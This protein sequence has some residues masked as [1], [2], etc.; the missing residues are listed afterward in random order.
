MTSSKPI[1]QRPHFQIASNLGLRLWQIYS[2]GLQFNPYQRTIP[3]RAWQSGLRNET[4]NRVQWGWGI[5]KLNR[6]LE[7]RVLCRKRAP[8]IC[9]NS[10]WAQIKMY[11][12]TEWNS[13][14][15][16]DQPESCESTISQSSRRAQ[17]AV[18]LDQPECNILFHHERNSIETLE[19]PQ[20]KA[21]Y[22]LARN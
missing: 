11:A 10:F 5:W 9:V 14:L 12:P 8:E 1:S 7:M 16:K 13:A 21:Y 3:G 18:S 17:R 19:E 2:E 15:T 22:R 20:G 6:I 4:K